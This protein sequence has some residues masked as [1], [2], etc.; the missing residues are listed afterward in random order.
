MDPLALRVMEFMPL[1]NTAP[2]NQF[3][4]HSVP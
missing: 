1:P 2:V 4:N 3:S